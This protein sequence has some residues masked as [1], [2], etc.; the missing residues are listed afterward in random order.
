M[1]WFVVNGKSLFCLYMYFLSSLCWLF[2]GLNCS[3]RMLLIVSTMNCQV[4]F[5]F[6]SVCSV[7]AD[8]WHFSLK[9]IIKMLN[10]LV[11]KDRKIWW[12]LNLLNLQCWNYLGITVFQYKKSRK[13]LQWNFD[14]NFIL[15]SGQNQLHCIYLINFI[16]RL[17]IISYRKY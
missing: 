7:L 10:L 6:T 13:F 9:I 4:S 11:F 16:S 2:G 5:Y 15:V 14:L 3:Y 8:V 1:N 12:L 17:Y